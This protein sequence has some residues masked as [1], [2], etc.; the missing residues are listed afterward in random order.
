M[1]FGGHGDLAIAPTK[2]VALTVFG[3]ELPDTPDLSAFKYAKTEKLSFAEN[4]AKTQGVPTITDGD[5][6][7]ARIETL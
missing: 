3:F 6:P 2:A 5:G 1:T 7:T 4:K